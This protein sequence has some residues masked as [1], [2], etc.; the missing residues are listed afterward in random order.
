MSTE[1]LDRIAAAIDRANA[2]AAPRRRASGGRRLIDCPYC[3]GSGRLYVETWHN[4]ECDIGPCRECDGTGECEIEVE[5]IG[6][7]I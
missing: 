7:G 4:P 5:P 6:E 2:A 1:L 3:G